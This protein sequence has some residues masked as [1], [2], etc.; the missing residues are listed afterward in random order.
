[1]ICSSQAK[2]KINID[3]FS[4]QRFVDP[5]GMWLFQKINIREYNIHWVGGVVGCVSV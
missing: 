1:M 3:S 4:Y 5:S 2:K